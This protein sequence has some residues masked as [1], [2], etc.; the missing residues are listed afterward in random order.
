MFILAGAGGI[1]GGGLMM[2]FAILREPRDKKDLIGPV[3]I[4]VF[5]G[6]SVGLS[7][8]PPRVPP[9]QGQKYLCRSCF[10][11]FTYFDHCVS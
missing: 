9:K 2:V 8:D 1:I 11:F 6:A 3:V 4:G 5:T 10:H 7:Y